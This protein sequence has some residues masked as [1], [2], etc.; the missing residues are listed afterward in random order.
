[1]DSAADSMPRD[2][3]SAPSSTGGPVHS[4]LILT[5]EE[6]ITLASR[7]VQTQV[8][9]C[10]K[11]YCFDNRTRYQCTVDKHWGLSRANAPLCDWGNATYVWMMDDLASDNKLE[12]LLTKGIIHV[13]RYW[14]KVVRSTVFLERFKDWRFRR[15]LRVP[16]YIKALDSDAHRIFWALREGDHP[17]NIAQRLGRPEPEVIKLIGRIHRTLA[18]RNRSDLLAQTTIVPL[19]GMDA[20]DEVYELNIPAEIS[21]HED[22]DLCSRLTTAY[23]MLT[24]QEQFLV[25]SMLIDELRAADVLQALLQQGVSLDET[26]PPQALNVQHIYYHLRKTLAKLRKLAGIDQES[27]P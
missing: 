9:S 12:R 25:D 19:H 20:E 18:K 4:S 3:S 1:M 16:P 8:M 23:S 26:V 11:R 7:V 13:D 10:C 14:Q 27:E 17:A 6:L 2:Q 5:R 24:W 15:R 22:S 21:S